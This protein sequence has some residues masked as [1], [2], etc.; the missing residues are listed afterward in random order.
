MTLKER[1][2]QDMRQ[3]QKSGEKLKLSLARLLKSDIRY[4]EIDKGK[5][6]SDEEVVEV[7][8]S[9]AKKHRDSIEQFR[10]GGR[11]D[12]VKQEEDELKMILEYMPEQLSVEEVGKLVEEAITEVGAE[13]EKD[14]GKVM[15]VLMP[16]VKGK[17]DGKV[18]SLLVSSRLKSA[19]RES[20]SNDPS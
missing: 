5:E 3:A 15:K 4:K 8:T 17:A 14:I 11:E 10:K 2:D 9:S 18:V 7:L 6:L 20:A 1:I 19:Q 16:K 12:L 13:G